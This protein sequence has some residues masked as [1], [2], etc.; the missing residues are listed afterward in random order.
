MLK[1]LFFLSSFLLINEIIAQKI[2]DHINLKTLRSKVLLNY[3]PR[4]RPRK[5]YDEPI[6]ITVMIRL[7]RLI[8][9]DTSNQRVDLSLAFYMFWTDEFLTW[10]PKKYG[11]ISMIKLWPHQVWLPDLFS[12]SPFDPHT[13]AYH[14]VRVQSTGDVFLIQKMIVTR[15][16]WMNLANFPF[17]KTTCQLNFIFPAFR[18]DNL[19]LEG[20][21]QV[22]IRDNFPAGNPEFDVSLSNQTVT[23]HQFGNTTSMFP[24]ITLQL[25]IT[26]K[27]SAYVYKILLPY[28]I[29][30]LCMIHALITY[31]TVMKR[32]FLSFITL[33]ID[34]YLFTY[35]W[36][37]IGKPS[38]ASTPY[39]FKCVVIN[40]LLAT[41]FI[42]MTTVADFW[43]NGS[44]NSC[45]AI[46]KKIVNNEL[47]SKYL[48]LKFSARNLK[49][50]DAE[51]FDIERRKRTPEVSDSVLFMVFLNRI[52]LVI[53]IVFGFFY[54][55]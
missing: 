22:I 15:Y 17:D 11:D 3:D 9:V 53:F 18:T 51:M 4:I 8:N 6:N 31:G 26:R 32:V 44:Q 7:D 37:M 48:F 19:R 10:D 42:I 49:D 13:E 27:T 52:F 29:A 5:N 1:I 45:P 24:Y 43:V 25:K 54:H 39:A 21:S 50:L 35:L 23:N 38:T 36:Y 34:I 2:D 46:G 30:N 12:S 20:E 28:L 33:F 47:V 41:A 14:K 40:A 16:C 55:S